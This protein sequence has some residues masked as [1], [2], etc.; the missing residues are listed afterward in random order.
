M[1]ARGEGEGGCGETST[2][3]HGKGR[4]GEGSGK[5]YQ[6]FGDT[7]ARRYRGCVKA[8]VGCMQVRVCEC[9]GGMFLEAR[10]FEGGMDG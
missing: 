10:S 4:G 2:V 6:M 8:L 5:N 9:P 3:G 1:T 7:A